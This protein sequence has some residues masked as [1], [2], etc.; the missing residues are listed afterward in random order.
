M[1]DGITNNLNP[2]GAPGIPGPHVTDIK[3]VDKKLEYTL[4]NGDSGVPVDLSSLAGV[5]GEKG[6][7]GPQGPKGD[8]GDKGDQGPKGERGEKGSRGPQGR[9]VDIDRVGTTAEMA[10]YADEAETFTFLDIEK[11]A[12]FVKLSGSK[13]DWS[14]PIPFAP[15]VKGDKGDAGQSFI[16]NATASRDEMDLYDP[17]KVK[18]KNTSFVSSPKGF[19][20]Y[21]DG[22][23]WF[24]LNDADTNSTW[25]NGTRFT[26][27]QGERGQGLV[28]D[29]RG[30]LSELSTVDAAFPGFTFLDIEN[31]RLYIKQ[32]ESHGDW[33]AFD[34]MKGEKG[35]TGSPGIQGEK[36]QGI[37]VDYY[38]S[39]FMVSYLTNPQ[40]S[41]QLND[42]V[43]STKDV[44][45]KD[46][47]RYHGTAWAKVLDVFSATDIRNWSQFPVV[48]A[49][50]PKGADGKDGARGDGLF[51]DASGTYDEL[52]SFSNSPKCSQGF[53]FL[54][55]QNQ[56]VYVKKEDYPYPGQDP[57]LGREDYPDQI[58]K[59][60]FDLWMAAENR[61]LERQRILW[62]EGSI[63]VGQTGPQGPTG[64]QGLQGVKGDKG[65][66]GD[67]GLSLEPT[68]KGPGLV[69][70]RQYD[71][72]PEGHSYLDTT[73]GLIYYRQTEE[74]GVWGPGIPLG[75]AG[76]D[77][78]AVMDVSYSRINGDPTVNPNNDQGILRIV[79]PSSG[80]S[81][82]E[83][84]NLYLT[85]ATTS[86][87]SFSQMLNPENSINLPMGKIHSK[88]RVTIEM[89]CVRGFTTSN[90]SAIPDADFEITMV[91]HGD[92]EFI[93][94]RYIFTDNPLANDD[95]TTYYDLLAS[96]STLGSYH[97]W[98]GTLPVLK[99]RDG[100]T[101]PDGS[102]PF[103]VSL[104][105]TMSGAF[106]PTAGTA[107]FMLRRD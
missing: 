19:C 55:V 73:H 49:Q 95:N 38:T 75:I 15:G 20:I 60:K 102:T 59:E 89:D 43:F 5:D 42:V 35:D 11:S 8:K 51:V 44:M 6:D 107:S 93:D 97:V 94:K 45:E 57:D 62:S 24:K 21:Y 27:V 80:G 36:G 47:V 101:I 12:I 76:V 72:A 106:V 78:Q 90:G 14:D 99:L 39:D 84:V 37:S 88:Q 33:S 28:V 32:S 26:G 87:L 29:H 25:S 16:I 1:I 103:N 4:S 63:K 64:P 22:S 82:N 70:R 91:I 85:G 71:S 69:P 18:P 9:S 52:E 105:V 83:S 48:G 68:Y 92:G 96:F 77:S 104:T 58:D 3:L 66:T 7:V 53:V 81:E 23:V 34:Y 67:K 41:H 74:H 65:D 46:G 54:D 30:P 17:T 61:P 79:K 50:G 98:E 86:N 56:V 100:T 40:V 10:A 2:C 31:N 13:N